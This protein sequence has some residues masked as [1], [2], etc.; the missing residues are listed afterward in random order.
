MRRGSR[1]GDGSCFQLLYFFWE[2]GVRNAAFLQ[3]AEGGGCKGPR[4][5][6]WAG[7]RVPRWGEGSGGGGLRRL[8]VGDGDSS[9]EEAVFRADV[10]VD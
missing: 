9:I 2:K 4:A 6:P 10:V 7:M 3:N 5:L 8:V 1:G